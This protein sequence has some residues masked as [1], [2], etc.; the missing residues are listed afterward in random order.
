MVLLKL[1]AITVI[2]VFIIDLAQF[3]EY[4]KRKLWKWLENKP[5]EDYRLKPFDCSLCMS[6]H[7]ML[8]YLICSGNFSL[9]MWMAVCLISYFSIHIKGLLEIVSELMIKAENKLN[10]IL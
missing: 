3:V 5:Y 10:D 2:V 6:H 4:L 8:L 1:L 7:I 9:G